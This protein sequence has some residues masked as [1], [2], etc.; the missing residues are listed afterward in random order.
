M[1]S[2]VT[3]VFESLPFGRVGS[4]PSMAKEIMRYVASAPPGNHLEIGVLHGGT[5]IMAALV[6][7]AKGVNGETIGV[8]P[9]NGFYPPYHLLPQG[10]NPPN[11]SWE[12]TE[13][14]ERTVRQNLQA[15]GVEKSVMLIKAF[16]YPWPKKLHYREFASVY[17]DGDHYGDAPLIDWVNVSRQVVDGGVVIFDDCN[18]NCPAVQRACA[19]AEKTPGWEKVAHAQNHAFILRKVR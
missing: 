17:I 5:L 10:H 9:L 1:D 2:I 14:S 13:I 4:W 11:K 3:R 15:F 19:I 12:D 18:D 16:S 8:D 6:R 7:E